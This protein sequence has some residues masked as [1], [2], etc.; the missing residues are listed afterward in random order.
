MLADDD[1]LE[2]EQTQPDL[3]EQDSQLEQ[4]SEDDEAVESPSAALDE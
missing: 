4:I 3:A 2:S 1:D